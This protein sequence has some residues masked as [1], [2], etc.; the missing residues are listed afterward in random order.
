MATQVYPVNQNQ[1][2]RLVVNGDLFLSGSN[3]SQVKLSVD[4]PRDLVVRLE[5][6][7]VDVLCRDDAA[8]AMRPGLPKAGQLGHR[9]RSGVVRAAAVGQFRGEVRQQ[10]EQAV[11]HQHGRL[12]PLGALARESDERCAAGGKYIARVALR[13]SL[14]AKKVQDALTTGDGAVVGAHESSLF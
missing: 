12:A 11:F 5:G 1:T 10:A 7:L 14:H 6:E 3:Q 8:L 4:E 13:S 2:L 9:F